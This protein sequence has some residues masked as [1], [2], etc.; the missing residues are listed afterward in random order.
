MWSNGNKILSILTKG[1]YWT[2]FSPS[3]VL[4]HPLQ[5]NLLLY[6]VIL[7]LDYLT[8]KIPKLGEATDFKISSVLPSIVFIIYSFKKYL[9]ILI[10]FLYLDSGSYRDRRVTLPLNLSSKNYWKDIILMGCNCHSILTWGH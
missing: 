2:L 10:H 3:T 4:N 6:H 5:A 9:Q 1:R 8:Y 7:W